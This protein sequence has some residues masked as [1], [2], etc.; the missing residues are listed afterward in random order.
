MSIADSMKRAL[1][2]I[3][4]RVLYQ[5]IQPTGPT[6]ALLSGLSDAV[7]V[8]REAVEWV[9]RA[10]YATPMFLSKCAVHGDAIAVDRMPYM[11]GNTRIELGSNIRISG[12]IGITSPMRGEPLLTIGDGVFIGHNC[13]IAIAKKVSIGKFASV[14]SGCYIADTEGHSHYNPEKP[15]WEVPAGDDDVAPVTIE[16]GVQISKNCMILK[17]VTIGARSVVGAGSV[18]RSDI[19]PDS[20]VM[21]N[22]A[23]VVK[24]MT[25]NTQGA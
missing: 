9:E 25:P 21:G 18:V 5:T 11:L 2:P 1:R 7:F 22:P 17:G 12:K 10:L 13:S 3:A 15:I 14:G 8:S 23:R 24:R 6:R 19:P 4:K 20:I 16:D